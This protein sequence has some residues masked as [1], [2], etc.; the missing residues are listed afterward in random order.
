MVGDAN[1]FDHD[2]D[3]GIIGRGNSMEE[4]FEEA[5]LAMFSLM[6]DLSAVSSKQAIKMTFEEDDKDL[7]FVTWL[8]LL[9]AEAQAEN[10]ILSSFKVKTQGHIWYGEATGE[11]W[12]QEIERGIDVKGATLTSLSVKE[13]NGKWEARCVVDV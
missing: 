2:A 1:Y 11:P 13:V 12:R 9:I 4:A 6:A 3:I 8:N 5:A 7:A 10:L